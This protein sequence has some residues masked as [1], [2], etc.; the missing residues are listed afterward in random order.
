MYWLRRI[1][2]ALFGAVLCVV[3]ASMPAVAQ[4][5][6]IQIVGTGGQGVN[7]RSGPSTATSIVGNIPE[8]ASPDYTCYVDGE[9]IGGGPGVGTTLWWRVSYQGVLGYYSSAY[10]NVP[11]GW[12]G[13]IETHY[14]VFRCSGLPTPSVGAYDR[15]AAVQW[16]LAH[17][18]DLQPKFPSPGCA[19][20]ASNVLWAGGLPKTSSWMDSG[21]RNPPRA[22]TYSPQ[23]VQYLW[24]EAGIADVIPLGDRFAPGR[25]AVP[26][27]QPGDLIVYDWDN[28]GI[29]DHTSVVVHIGDNSYP[30][31][32]EWGTAE[33]AGSRSSYVMR[34]W[35]WSERHPSGWLRDKSPRVNA[36][37]VHIK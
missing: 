7:V 31:V 2:I 9:R 34:G 25:N 6:S 17:V 18:Q 1:G 26:E 13:D 29:L 37:L 24:R 19:W 28:D 22:A 27:A 11:Y 30:D 23:L 16:A 32:S 10:D 8:G 20:F 5:A 33:G 36:W 4:N 14:N 21:L 15:Q 12:Q 3:G 35:T